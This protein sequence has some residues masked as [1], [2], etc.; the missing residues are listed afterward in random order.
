M[1]QR[2]IY[3]SKELLEQ[4][5]IKDH[6]IIA[7]K[8]F[9][10]GYVVGIDI[11]DGDVLKTRRFVEETFCMCAKLIYTNSSSHEHE[12]RSLESARRQ[13]KTTWSDVMTTSS[14]CH[15]SNARRQ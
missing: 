15:P 13:R 4:A 1:R 3:I 9:C 10:Y 8:T 6:Y 12:Q 11:L 14:A 2:K 5:V 7:Q